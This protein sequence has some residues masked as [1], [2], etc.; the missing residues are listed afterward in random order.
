MSKVSRKFYHYKLRTC[1]TLHECAVC[2]KPITLGEPY[3]D[4]G[5]GRRAH[6][7]CGANKCKG[8]GCE[9]SPDSTYCGEC[10]CEEDSL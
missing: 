2:E 7:W 4:G 6:R 5:Y 8:C 1:L 9:I 10:L 3:F